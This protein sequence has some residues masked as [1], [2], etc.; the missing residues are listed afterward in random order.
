MAAGVREQL[1]KLEARIGEAC[2]RVGRHRADVTLVAVTKTATPG[3]IAEILE[4]GVRDLGENR[5]QV[6]QQHISELAGR[7]VAAQ[8]RWHM[9]GHLQRNKVRDLLPRVVMIQSVDSERLAE[10]IDREAAHLGRRMPVLMEVN[11]GGEAQKYGIGL[12][13]AEGLLEKMASLANVECQGL[14][15][16]APLTGEQHRIATTF[17]RTR[18]LFEVLRQKPYGRTLRHLSMGMSNDF[19]CA[20]EHGATIVRVGSLLFGRASAA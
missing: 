9:I 19:E 11:A 7:P 4:A 3:Q 10:V 2:G 5:V 17:A 1:I 20:I 12:R 18:E 16:M 6:L 15:S 8:A 13:E 14:M